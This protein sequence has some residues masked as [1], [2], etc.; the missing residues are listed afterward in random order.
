VKRKDA[1]FGNRNPRVIGV[2]ALS[3]ATFALLLLPVGAA[4]AQ[5][6]AD[7]ARA[8]AKAQACEGCHGSPKAAPLEGVPTLA[9][10]QQEFLVLQM[11]LMREGLRDVPQ[12][13][14]LLKDYTDADL[15]EVGGYFAGQK[16]LTVA[17][18]PDPKR[19][20]L[21]AGLA[22][23][24][25]CGSCHLGS[26]QGQRQVPRLTNQREDYL[27]AAMRAYRDNKR[28]GSD[29]SMNSIMYRTSDADIDAL[30]HYL[31][32]FK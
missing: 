22:Q 19:Q 16:P 27:A 18:K 24:M 23:T 20:A 8:A 15:T 31:A 28:S 14:G 25:G 11:F 9:G 32:H 6:R 3:F 10:Q 7:P 4:S 26:Y 12:M 2:P 21:G 29:T 30:A 5:S 17:T 1:T 13:A